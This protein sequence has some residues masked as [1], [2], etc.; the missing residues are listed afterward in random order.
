MDDADAD[1]AAAD[2]DDD[3]DDDDGD[4]DGDYDSIN[5]RSFGCTSSSSV[6]TGSHSTTSV[7][8]PLCPAVL[9]LHLSLHH[10]CCSVWQ[11][12][13]HSHSYYFHPVTSSGL[14]ITNR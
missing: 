13:L 8:L 14:S 12:L 6:Y 1:A 3:D 7:A 2:D 11:V 9:P 5:H 4:D 10:F